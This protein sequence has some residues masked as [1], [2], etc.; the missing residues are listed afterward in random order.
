MKICFKYPPV[1]SDISRVENVPRVAFDENHRRAADVVG[2]K[3]R[4][5]E[6]QSCRHFELSRF[7][8]LKFLLNQTYL[9]RQVNEGY[10]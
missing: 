1:K 9:T 6:L 5:C 4:D 3:Q 2:V 10:L 7:V 8:I